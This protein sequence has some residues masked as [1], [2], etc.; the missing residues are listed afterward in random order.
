MFIQLTNKHGT[1][2][3][4]NSSTIETIGPHRSDSQLMV[5]FISGQYMMVKETYAEISTKLKL[6]L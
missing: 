3:M 5:T 1:K 4:V 2:V 6:N